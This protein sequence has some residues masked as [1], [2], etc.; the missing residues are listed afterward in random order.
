[1]CSDMPST[2]RSGCNARVV[3]S[4][5]SDLPGLPVWLIMTLV[6]GPLH[7]LLSCLLIVRRIPAVPFSYGGL[8]MFTL[9]GLLRDHYGIGWNN[10]FGFEPFADL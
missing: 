10:L 4:L 7:L 8:T 1:M 3:F 2:S 5:L 6:M 9:A